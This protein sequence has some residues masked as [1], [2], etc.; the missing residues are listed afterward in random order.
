MK[1][2][3]GKI[4]GA[5]LF[6]GA[7]AAIESWPEAKVEAKPDDSVRPVRSVVAEKGTRLPDLYFTGKVKAD[8][9]RT[10]CFKQSGRIQRIPVAAGQEIK[11]GDKLFVPKN[12]RAHIW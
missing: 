2:S 1:I 3:I 4:I 12:K 11:K 9:D 6:A 7:V 5:A 8:S 10:L